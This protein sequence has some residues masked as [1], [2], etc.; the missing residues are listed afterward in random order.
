ME[1]KCPYSHQ[2]E[3][4]STAAAV[5]K[6]FCLKDTDGSLHLDHAHSYYYQVQTQMFVC[7]L[8]Y[9]DFTVCTFHDTEGLYT[10]RIYRDEGFWQQCW[11]KAQEFFNKCI[12]PELVGKWFTRSHDTQKVNAHPTLSDNEDVESST[13]TGTTLPTYCI[14]G[15]PAEGKMIGCDNK[16]CEYEWFHLKCLNL[17]RIPKGDWYCP[18]C[19]ISIRDKGTK[20]K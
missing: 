8:L 12:L 20:S 3:S 13:C 14:C 4:I 17:K 7:S 1:I 19:S 18:D 10:E 9:C 15:K 5:D 11:H 2:H 16:E 6:T